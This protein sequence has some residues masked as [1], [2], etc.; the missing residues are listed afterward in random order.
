MAALRVY[1]E[2]FGLSLDAENGPP[3]S[4]RSAAAGVAGADC[5]G[6]ETGSELS[7]V[8]TLT[9]DWTWVI[10]TNMVILMRNR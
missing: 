3:L 5:R 2:A 6:G 7:P 8:S 9:M 10:M 4:R 1:R